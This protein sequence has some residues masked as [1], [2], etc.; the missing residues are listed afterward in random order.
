MGVIVLPWLVVVRT[1]A[2]RILAAGEVLPHPV[3]IVFGAGLR[4][5]GRPSPILA[6]RVRTA[7]E[8]YQSGKIQ[9][10]LLSGSASLGYDE[11]EAMRQLAVELGV[12]TEHLMVDR[13]GSRTFETCRRAKVEFGVQQAI[14]ISQRFH[15]PR[16]LAICQG[17]KIQAVGVASDRR[18]YRG[19]AQRYWQ[20]REI[21]ATL[22]AF[23]DLLFSRPE[24]MRSPGHVDEIIL[25]EGPGVG[26]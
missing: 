21:P 6:D 12:P 1:Y 23:L 17:L 8:L 18:T 22:V 9:A 2:A 24:A 14:L 16:A 25:Q 5:D 26:P 13:G 19:S 7:V 20:L 4:R 11:P 10:L 15:L 3:G